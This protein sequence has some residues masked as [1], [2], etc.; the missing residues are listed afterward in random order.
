M[1]PYT[2]KPYVMDVEEFRP[3]STQT[4]SIFREVLT[5]AKKQPLAV[6]FVSLTLLIAQSPIVFQQLGAE[7]TD[8]EMI[9]AGI[10]GFLISVF[11]TLAATAA[12]VRI[13]SKDHFGSLTSGIFSGMLRIVT[14][15]VPFLFLFL[16]YYLLV[17]AGAMLFAAPVLLPVLAPPFIDAVDPTLLALIGGVTSVIGL[18]V[19]FF[20]MIRT[21]LFL[22]PAVL[23]LPRPLST[24]IA[25]TRGIFWRIVLHW[26]VLLAIGFL[27]GVGSSI[28]SVFLAPLSQSFATGIPVLVS[29]LVNVMV[30]GYI[31]ILFETIRE[32]S[33]VTLPLLHRDTFVY[34][35]LGGIGVIIVLFLVFGWFVGS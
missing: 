19:L 27:V 32:E 3:N 15:G 4:D 10:I 21:M 12:T 23:G 14:K 11:G 8:H 2:E 26:V 13:F 17:A 28:L 25:L 29:V 33:Q 9:A 24:S 30:F 31:T 35:M 7:L 1:N 16:P 22:P 18:I 20:L 5:R 34:K 6:F